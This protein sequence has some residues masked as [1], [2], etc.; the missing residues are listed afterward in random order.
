[1]KNPG[2]IFG[3][4]IKTEK[5]KKRRYDDSPR[6]KRSMRGSL[7]FILLFIACGILFTRLVSLQVVKGSYYRQL[8]DSNRTRTTVIH[9][10]RG[11]IFDRNGTPLVFNTPGYRKVEKNKTSFLNQNTALQL[12]AKG[13]RNIEVDSLRK[14]PFKEAFAHVI[15]YVGQISEEGLKDPAYASYAPTDILGKTGIEREY[16]DMLRGKDG[17]ELNEVDAT[18]KVLRTLGETDPIPGKDITLT[19]DA[20]LQQK[21]Y[22]AMQKVQ[23]GALIISKPDGEILSLVSM[24]SFDPNL[25]TLGSDYKAS[26]SGY[27]NVTSILVDGKN[28]P[29]L[30][31][32]I[33]GV[34][35]PGSTFKLVTAAA[36]LE[37]KI[38]DRNYQVDD[39]GVIKIG[40]FS[41]ANWYYLE[42][43]KTDGE[44]N[45]VK[46]IARSND[47][48][49]YKLAEKVG[50]TKLSEEAKKFGMGERLGIDLD[51]E[52]SG[53][54]PTKQWK[55]KTIGEDWYLGDTYHYG[56]GQG[57]LL[58]TPLQVN[59]W[60]QAIANGGILY[61]P[62]L[63]QTNTPNAMGERFLSDSTVSL[64]REGMIGSCNTGGVAWPFFDFKVKNANLPIDGKNFTAAQTA[65][66]SA[67]VSDVSDYR[68]VAVACKTGTAQYGDEETSP[69]AWI[70]LYAPAYNPEIVV[71]V[72]SEE[73]GQGS[74][75]AGPIA[76]EV[77]TAYFEGKKE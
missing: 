66:G 14:Y 30:N 16:E 73:S 29:L 2:L 58:S 75:V 45:V 51:G 1:M 28:Q 55:Q 19:L 70:T 35:P 32:A 67:Q 4:H 42:N 74:N 27:Q 23:R 39:T 33:G 37:D 21:A 44:V 10:P 17:K 18:G 69:H 48:F 43:G 3:E 60:T 9:A 20:D 76:K 62:H 52:E 46:A 22:T 53:L 65:S 71:T 72:L 11:V 41:F 6:K 50:V 5:I 47:I 26:S 12:I 25:F 7:L 31:R 68:H 59:A 38:I 54:V 24:P 34:Y 77:V 56:I 64:I 36:G 13:A 15:G 49:F 63:L 40:S 57:Y 61:R 8:A